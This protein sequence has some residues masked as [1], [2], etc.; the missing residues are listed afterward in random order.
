MTDKEPEER[1]HLV[2]PLDWVLGLGGTAAVITV[3]WLSL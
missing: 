1:P 3:L 2:E